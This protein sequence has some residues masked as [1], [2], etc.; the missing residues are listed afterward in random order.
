MRCDYLAAALAVPH[1][2]PSRVDKAVW[3]LCRP[4]ILHAF[5]KEIE[6]GRATGRKPWLRAS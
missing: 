6:Y 1:L 5:K 4:D 2:N 3:A